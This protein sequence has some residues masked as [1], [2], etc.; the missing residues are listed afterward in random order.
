ASRE[1]KMA[2]D[3][4]DRR[5]FCVVATA[6][7]LAVPAA[8]APTASAQDTGIQISVD[9]A[10]SVDLR[11]APE[12]PA[13]PRPAGLVTNR[14]TIPMADYLAAKNAAAARAPSGKPGA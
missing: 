1:G 4:R 5:W 11:T 14:P 2:N 13:V 10:K 7:S 12:L 9:A 6:A 8:I 3:T